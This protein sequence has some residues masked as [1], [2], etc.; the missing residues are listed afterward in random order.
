MATT[1]LPGL[2]SI[3]ELVFHINYYTRPIMN[4]L[5]GKP[6]DASDKFSFDL[7]AISSEQDWQ[8]LVKKV[9]SDSELLA[10]EIEKVADTKLPEDFSD[11]KYGSYYR[12]LH[13]IIEHSYYHLGQISMIKKLLKT[14]SS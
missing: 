2:H 13:G 5:H 7:P 4:G 11:P 12:N 8:E 6:L 9:F 3:A 14:N 1:K 10:A